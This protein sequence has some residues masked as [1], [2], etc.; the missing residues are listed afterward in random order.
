MVT[1]FCCFHQGKQH[2]PL[3]LRNFPIFFSPIL[4]YKFT[5]AICKLI[6]S[7]LLLHR[8]TN[9]LKIQCT[10]LALTCE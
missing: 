8:F 4:F 5:G 1:N 10:L 2:F 7:T 9:H 3:S 6:D